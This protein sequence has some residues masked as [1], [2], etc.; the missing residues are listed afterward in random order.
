[1]AFTNRDIAVN[2]LRYWYNAS[3]LSFV[4][5]PGYITYP[6]F[7]A[8]IDTGIFMDSLG[9]AMKSIRQDKIK[10]AYEALAASDP[11]SI[12]PKE[13]FFNSL[14]ISQATVDFR[15]VAQATTDVV[16]EDVETAGKIAAVGLGGYAL[17]LALAGLVILLPSIKKALA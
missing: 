11:F 1:M 12:P 7:I 15:T 5:T 4:V 2:N 8:K 17:Y 16:K 9:S 13:E 3:N 14:A 10:A 6:A